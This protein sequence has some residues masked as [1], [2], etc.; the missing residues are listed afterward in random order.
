LLGPGV[1]IGFGVCLYGQDIDTVGWPA[2]GEI[3]ATEVALAPPLYTVRFGTRSR[4]LRWIPDLRDLAGPPLVDRWAEH[5]LESE[6]GRI[7][8][9]VDGQ[10]YHTAEA[11]DPRAAAGWPFDQPFV[12]TIVLIIGSHLSGPVQLETWPRAASGADVDAYAIV[13]FIRFEQRAS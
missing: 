1:G 2:C 4:L 5:V 13:D 7:S 8:W 12:V 6:A 11:S 9:G 3:D 10:T